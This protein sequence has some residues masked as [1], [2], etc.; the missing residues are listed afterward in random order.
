MGGGDASLLRRLSPAV[1]LTL[2]GGF[3]RFGGLGGVRLTHDLAWQGWEAARIVNGVYPL[4]GQPSSVFLDNPPLMG[5]IQAIPLFFWRSPWSIFIFITLLNTLAIPFVYAAVEPLFGRRAAVFSAVLF[6]INPWIAHFSRFTWTQGLLPFFLAVMFWG[7]VPLCSPEPPPSQ[8]GFHWRF[9]AGWLALTGLCMTYVLSLA[10]LAPAGL[11]LLLFW[12]RLP[13]RSLAAGVAVLA[14][15][16]GVYGW[17]VID[18]LDQN[19]GKFFDFLNRAGERT[20]AAETGDET[21]QILN[22]TDDALKHAL[23]FVT[24]RDYVGQDFG[25]LDVEGALP[26]PIV[27]QLARWVLTAAFLIGLGQLLFEGV[28]NGRPAG[29]L[30]LIWF[31][32]P[33]GL[34]MV[35]PASVFVHPHYLLFTLPAGSVIAAVGLDRCVRSTAASVWQPVSLW[36]VGIFFLAVGGQFAL[37][38]GQSSQAAQAHPLARGLDSLPL[39]A[40]A[41][42][43]DDIRAFYAG[44]AGPIPQRVHVAANHQ[45][46]SAMSGMWLESTQELQPPVWTLF[47]ASGSMLSVVAT[48]QIPL[49][50]APAAVIEQADGMSIL[51]LEPEPLEAPQNA[52][53][54]ESEAGLTFLGHSAA[55]FGADELLVTTYW[56]VDVLHAARSEWFVSPFVHVIDGEGQTVVNVGPHGRWGYLWRVGDVY[57]STV[58]VERPAAAAKLGIGLFDPISGRTFLLRGAEGNMPRLEVGLP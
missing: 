5:Y 29:W 56:R 26:V 54:V 36:L 23:R 8:P 50:V 48:H 28:S 15:A 14:L 38:L 2:L 10:M 1:W 46:V 6:A 55:D 11:L 30:L 21:G 53:E 40:A 7:W 31:F 37:S 20:G 22:F 58:A 27:S 17:G 39:S 51:L 32:V 57:V 24:G 45:I 4:L 25:G 49:D 13:Q 3:F 34:M 16:L 18:K 44:A 52:V 19:S 42:V 9:F 41:A 43:G 35:L 47:P 12:R 33:V